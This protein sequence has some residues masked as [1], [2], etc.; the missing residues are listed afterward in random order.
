MAI[1]SVRVDS[2]VLSAIQSASR[3]VGVDFDYM[4]KKAGVESNFQTDIKAKTSSATGLYQ[5]LDQTWLGMIKRH[6]ERHGLG[7]FAAEISQDDKGRFQVEDPRMKDKILSM[8][9]DPKTSALMAAE[10]A[11]DNANY[12]KSGGIESVGGTE[13]YLAHFLGAGGARKFLSHMQDNPQQNAASLFPAAAKAN[14]NVFYDPQG[15]ARSLKDVHA[16]FEKRMDQQGDWEIAE[17]KFEK[18]MPMAGSV[19]ESQSNV[20]GD[21]SKMDQTVRSY[22]QGFPNLGAG[23]LVDPTTLLWLLQ[24]DVPSEA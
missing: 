22:H 19:F 12:L 10:F 5:F 9:N 11:S 8:R 16:F 20:L 6:G 24:L 17:S 13:L 14:K 4:V 23:Q 18:P 1:H 21:F 7:R 3:K 2:N 15:R